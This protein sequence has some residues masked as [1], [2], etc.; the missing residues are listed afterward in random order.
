MAMKCEASNELIITPSEVRLFTY[1]PRL[2]FYETHLPI[3]RGLMRR[4][5]LLL[6]KLYHLLIEA[7]LLIKVRG[8][9]EKL[10]ESRIGGFILRGKPDIYR[11]NSDHIEVIEIKSSKS[12]QRGVWFTDKMQ[13]ASYVLLLT[14]KTGK[15]VKA[16]ILYRD[17]SEEVKISPND[18]ATL[19]KVFEGIVYIKKYGLFPPSTK[20]KYK[21]MKCEYAQLCSIVDDTTEQKR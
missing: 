7:L 9:V 12:P 5:R 6:G 15:P 4:L 17:R 10:I 8:D 3:K 14:T 2:V 1:C 20:N 19:F 16:K 13:L 21:C 11:E 18:I